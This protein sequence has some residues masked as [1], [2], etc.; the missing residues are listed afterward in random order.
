MGIVVKPGILK[1]RESSL[2]ACCVS[3]LCTSPAKRKTV[4]S[5]EGRAW[6]RLPMCSAGSHEQVGSVV[7][8]AQPRP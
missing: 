8:S 6:A 4:L 5:N 3:A 7:A 1:S 2:Q